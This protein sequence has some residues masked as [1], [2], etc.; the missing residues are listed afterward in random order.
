MLKLDIILRLCLKLKRHSE[1]LFFW[2]SKMMKKL[3]SLLLDLSTRSLPQ[4]R[5]LSD[6][7][8]QIKKKPFFRS[9]SKASC[10]LRFL[11]LHVTF[12]TRTNLGTCLGK[13]TKI[14]LVHTFTLMGMPKPPKKEN[15]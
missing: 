12:S 11:D 10:I 13:L 14:I 5:S 2:K 15:K 9:C 1:D 8:L 7:K 4:I 6:L 3:N